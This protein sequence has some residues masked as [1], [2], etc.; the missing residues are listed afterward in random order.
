MV[1]GLTEC[2]NIIRVCPYADI[3]DPDRVNIAK[4]LGLK[5]EKLKAYCARAY[6]GPV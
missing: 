1:Y 2:R 3:S 6:R 4:V 5:L